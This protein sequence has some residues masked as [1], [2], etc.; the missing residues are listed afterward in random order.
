MPKP[1]ATPVGRGPGSISPEFTAPSE[2][3]AMPGRQLESPPS[4]AEQFRDA[5]MA[6]GKGVG[7]AVSARAA[8]NSRL[9]TLKEQSVKRVEADLARAARSF[10]Q[11]RLETA[12]ASRREILS[13]AGAGDRSIESV[14]REFRSRMVNAG[15]AQE[16]SLW[17]S[18]WSH[19][20]SQVSRENE[21]E[22]RQAFNSAKMTMSEVTLA[23][24]AQL[25]ESPNLRTTLTG[26]GMNIGARVQDWMLEELQQS[27]NMESLTSE[28]GELLIHQTIVQSAGI[29]D[30]LRATHQRQVQDTHLQ[31][32]TRQ[33][34]ADILSTAQG[35]Q[36][37][38]HL[39][40]QVETTLRDNL[41][42]LSPEQQIGF[43]REQVVTSLKS[44]ASGQL[45]LNVTDAI[46][47]TAPLLDLTI[48]GE[49]IFNSQER[50]ALVAELSSAGQRAMQ[51]KAEAAASNLR[52]QT[53]IPVA[54]DGGV[55]FRPNPDAEGALLVQ[56]ENG[57]DAYAREANRLLA[58]QGLLGLENPTPEQSVMTAGVRNA[59]NAH[60]QAGASQREK[61]RIDTANWVSVMTGGMGDGNSAWKT[62]PFTRAR[63]SPVELTANKL[64]GMSA[65][66]I[67]FVKTAM[68]G[69]A[70]TDEEIAAVR[71]WNGE[72]VEY[73]DETR[74]LSRLMAMSEARQWDEPGVQEL[75]GM[76]DKLVRSK[77]ALLKS[78]DPVQVEAFTHW[79]V[80]LDSGASEGWNNFLD[81][82]SPNEAA[83]ANW[84]R[85]HG[86]LG[87][88]TADMGTAVAAA[89]ADLMDQVQTILNAPGVESWL[90]SDTG[91]QPVQ[92]RYTNSRNMADVLTAIIADV[93]GAEF[94]D[95][96]NLSA[97]LNAMILSD[98]TG[99]GRSIR[100]LWFSGRAVNPTM[101]DAQVG[102][103][104]YHWLRKDG[105]TFRTINEKAVMI[106][107]PVGYLG[108]PGDDI[109]DFTA[110]QFMRPFSGTTRAFLQEALGIASPMDVPFNLQHMLAWDTADPAKDRPFEPGAIA[111]SLN[112]R[113]QSS[114]RMLESRA[115]FG[116]VV[117]SGTNN[118]G[119]T[120][121]PV[122]SL[123]DA[124]LQWSDGTSVM[125]PRGTVLN[126]INPDLFAPLR[127]RGDWAESMVEKGMEVQS[128][129]P[130]YHHRTAP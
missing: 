26:D 19:A 39:R 62:N 102:Q 114:A 111:P 84:I 63:M 7:A 104:I 70:S 121:D 110:E 35:E 54:V 96:S 108:K 25:A 112:F 71:Q 12:D 51:I 118:R 46:T 18:A 52:E 31:N 3:V 73:T 87:Q 109:N 34:S 116:G 41:S 98:R 4:G 86:R 43:V 45:G 22:R 103:M 65:D 85:I 119:I 30:T 100:Q 95:E 123:H 8:V 2:G 127:K 48:D 81:A 10:Q 93:S 33:M 91:T 11:R 130:V 89:P 32:G 53:R 38:V 23:L 128:S 9:K 27:M 90:R 124:V 117:V 72:P 80:S 83:A 36:D 113:D 76:P 97:Q 92:E 16:A 17:E 101:D 5:V 60:R 107:D 94:D 125:V 29:A 67:Q 44:L 69:L 40:M 50:A 61:T 6:F 82:I 122:V 66:D 58:E 68:M 88:P 57:M 42:H 47:N 55:V 78:N 106:Q 49:K 77:M 59:M 79:A 15:S 115:N 28:D 24:S 37:P 99:I 126:V 14:E 56:D 13:E 74:V 105:M 20:A 129:V 64:N 75:T 1:T 120:L 21:E